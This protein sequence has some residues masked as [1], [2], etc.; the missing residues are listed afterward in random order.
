MD[1]PFKFKQFVRNMI[2]SHFSFKAHVGY[3]VTR[4]SSRINILKV[5]AGTNRGQQ[6][7][8]IHITYIS[9][10]RSIFMYAAPIYFPNASSSLVQ[11]FQTI[12][13]SALRVATD[14]VKM[15]SIDHLCE[16]TK[17]LLVQDDL[18]QSSSQYLVSVLQRQPTHQPLTNISSALPFSNNPSHSV[19]TSPSGMRKKNLQSRFFHRVAP[20][21]SNG[22]NYQVPSY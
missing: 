6:M 13:N 10:I 18:S 16:E 3:I 20:N 21:L 19:V 1:I 2:V 4:V 11:K 8:T 17:M 15:I 5:H 22:I 9:L 12:Q 14:S 7:E